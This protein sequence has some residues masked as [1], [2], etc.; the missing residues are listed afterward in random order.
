MAMSH[1]FWSRHFTAVNQKQ[2]STM[3]DVLTERLLPAFDNLDA[4]AD[5]KAD[6]AWEAYGSMACGEYGPLL[7]ESEAAELAKQAGMDHYRALY[8]ARQTLLN[9]FAVT[10]YHLWE[11]QALA[12]HRRQVLHPAEENDHKLLTL[13][14]FANRLQP[15]GVDVRSLPCWPTL[16]MFRDLANTIKHA[17]GRA[18][19]SLKRSHPQWFVPPSMRDDEFASLWKAGARVYQPLAGDDVYVTL[20]DLGTFVRT[21]EQFWKEL[22]TALEACDS[23]SCAEVNLSP[24]HD[25]SSL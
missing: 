1:Q 22:V 7:D 14:A 25:T 5:A 21:T 4:E 6:E 17:D 11:Q 18:A 8:A 12:F 13:E 19:D 3:L 9:S 15:V 10:L 20:E 2:M 23:A 16:C 24:P